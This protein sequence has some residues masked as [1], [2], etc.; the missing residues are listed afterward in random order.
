MRNKLRAGI[1]GLGVGEEHLKGYLANPNCQVKSVCDLNSDHLA[2]VA[3]QYSISERTTKA[4][5]VL[6]DPEIDIVSICSYDN[7]HAEQVVMAL[8]NGK[9]VMVEKPICLYRAEAEKIVA[10]IKKS[11]RK[12]SS[13]LVLRK[14]PRFINLKEKIKKDLFGQLFYVEGDYLYGRGHKITQGWRGKLDFYCG[15]YGG[16]V[17]VIDL[18]LW[19]VDSEVEE[20]FS[21]GNN[22]STQ[23]TNFK[24]DD[25]IVSIIKFKNGCIGKSVTTL[26]SI[27]P[28][29]HALKV[30]GTKA[31][32]VNNYQEADLYQGTNH[33]DHSSI[34]D[35]YPGVSKAVLLPDFIEAVINDKR[36]SVNEEDV[37]K[38]MA[39]C[40][41]MYES[42]QSGKSEKVK[43]II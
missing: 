20:V 11:K 17:H 26:C 27:M 4:E 10:A 23:D 35:D 43:Y 18:L 19:F 14:S 22:I 8:E 5:N 37:F 39:V 15:V 24:Y 42:L 40:F 36:P 31:T 29:F 6:C 7:F 16:G 32:F 12:L 28:H 9:H 2:Q 13:N 34:N 1:I 21:Y 3:D 41:A 30:F 33:K 38:T 25:C